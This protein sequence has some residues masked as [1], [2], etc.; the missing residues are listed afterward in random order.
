[1]CYVLMFWAGRE[2][3][4]LSQSVVDWGRKTVVQLLTPVSLA[5]GHSSVAFATVCL[6]FWVDRK[7]TVFPVLPWLRR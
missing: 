5:A 4:R 1:M 7:L 6:A 3:R 2:G